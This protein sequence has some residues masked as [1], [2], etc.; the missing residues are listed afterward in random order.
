M[1]S[2][3]STFRYGLGKILICM[4]HMDRYEEDHKRKETIGIDIFITPRNGKCSIMQPAEMSGIP[5]ARIRTRNQL[6]KVS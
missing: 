2:C 5:T 4:K 6:E 3:S 1:Q